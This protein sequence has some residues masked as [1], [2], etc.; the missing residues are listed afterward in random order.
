M[1]SCAIVCLVAAKEEISEHLLFDRA[2]RLLLA[3]LVKDFLNISSTMPA[4]FVALRPSVN[5]LFEREFAIKRFVP[6]NL[7]GRSLDCPSSERSSLA[8][9]WA[10]KL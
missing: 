9:D 2:E 3:F 7:R 6:E 1:I 10:S 5:C 4:M 8:G